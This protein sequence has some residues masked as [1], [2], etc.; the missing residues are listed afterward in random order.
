VGINFPAFLVL[1][2]A[3]WLIFGVFLIGYWLVE[4]RTGKPPRLWDAPQHGHTGP[5]RP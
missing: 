2:I 5:W 4:K 3:P 1:V